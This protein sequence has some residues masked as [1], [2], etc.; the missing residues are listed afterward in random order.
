MKFDEFTG[1]VQHKARLATTDEALAA[2]RATLETLAE[3]TAGDQAENLAAQLPNEIGRYLHGKQIF[4]RFSLAD[5]FDRV[6]DKEGVDKPVA[7][8]HARAVIDVLQE[9]VS[10][11]EIENLRAQLPDEWDPLFEQGAEGDL[12]IS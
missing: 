8:F 1:K 3:R 9:A 4:E 12:D 2:I 5:F 10:A 7:V 11:G 6:T